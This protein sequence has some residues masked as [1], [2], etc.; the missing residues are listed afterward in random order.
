MS[1]DPTLWC[2]S[3]TL[4][5][6]RVLSFDVTRTTPLLQDFVVGNPKGWQRRCPFVTFLSQMPNG[7]V[8]EQHG[9]RRF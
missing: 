7:P 8:N 5:N 2:L 9:S 1:E 3:N 6:R 4:A